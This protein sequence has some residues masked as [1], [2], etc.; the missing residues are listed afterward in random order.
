[1]LDRDLLKTQGWAFGSLFTCKTAPVLVSDME[2]AHQE[3]PLFMAVLNDCSIIS[4]NLQAEPYLEYLAVTPIAKLNN[5]FVLTRSPRTLHIELIDS[6]GNPYPV[7]LSMARRGFIARDRLEAASVCTQYQCMPQQ[8]TIIKRWL[9][10]RYAGA[11]WPDSFNTSMAPI[12]KSKGAFYRAMN[13]DIGRHCHSLYAGID[14][15]CEIEG[16]QQYEQVEMVAV[17]DEDKQAE[18]SDDAIDDFEQRVT[19]IL[20]GVKQFARAQFTVMASHDVTLAHIQKMSR[21]QFDYLS[22]RQEAEI[23]ELEHS[24]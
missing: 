6:A 14:P 20:M 13:S 11:T 19:T 24:F 8:L 4:P 1:M 18:F 5:E 10:N 23:A 7:E 12:A 15:N 2:E 22:L 16:N 21:F 17:I 9:A 3:S